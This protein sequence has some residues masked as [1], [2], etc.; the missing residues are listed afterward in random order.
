MGARLYGITNRGFL[1]N[2]PF[3]GLIGFDGS[4][5]WVLYQISTIHH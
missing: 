5:D 3:F 4:V 2:L 1:L